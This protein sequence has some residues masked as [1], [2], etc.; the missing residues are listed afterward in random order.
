MDA[1][2]IRLA[3]A[4]ATI[5]SMGATYRSPNFTVTAPTPQMA[6]Q[7][8]EHAEHHRRELAVA[9][10]GHELPNWYAPCPVTVKVGQLG[11]GG[12][13][14]FSFDRGATGEMEVFGWKMVVQGTLERVLDSVIPH[15]VSHTIFA[16]HFR[17]PLPRWADEGAATLAEHESEKR[18]QLLMVNQILHTSQR[19]PLRQLLS[20]KEY[21]N[22]PQAVLSLYAQG[23]TLAELLV[24][25]EGK[26][27]YLQF[28]AES[29]QLGWEQAFKKHYGY[30]SLDALEQRWTKWIEDGCPRLDTPEEPVLVAE[31]ESD[32]EVV[33]RSQTPDE[34][35]ADSPPRVAVHT[36]QSSR[37]VAPRAKLKARPRPLAAKTSVTAA[38]KQADPDSRYENDGWIAIRTSGRALPAIATSQSLAA[39]KRTNGASRNTTSSGQPRR[40]SASRDLTLPEADDD[41]PRDWPGAVRAQQSSPANRRSSERSGFPNRTSQ[42]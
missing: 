6:Q 4:A 32:D 29:D 27:R 21:P 16:C 35:E 20:M 7:V 1:L 5:T 24:Q 42:P 33:V 34:P 41:M 17:Q 37:L 12:Y 18:R 10:L 11:A 26:A 28:L 36:G 9:W 39:A 15:E 3:L 30:A 40:R 23:Y 38:A 8:A 22:D 31:N 2:L 13:T 25:T 19:I 14:S